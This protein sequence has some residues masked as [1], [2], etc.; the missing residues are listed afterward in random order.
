[1]GLKRDFKRLE[2]EAAIFAPYMG[3]KS[4]PFNPTPEELE[5]APY[6]GLKS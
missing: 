5:F 3:L 6:M 4:A 1:M 2:K